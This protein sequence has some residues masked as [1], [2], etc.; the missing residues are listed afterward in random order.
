MQGKKGDVWLV[1]NQEYYILCVQVVYGTTYGKEMR[2]KNILL[3]NAEKKRDL[4]KYPG[5]RDSTM[6]AGGY[7]SRGQLLQ[8]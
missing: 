1:T 5:E 7:Y 3:P 6:Q 4:P 8:V 2:V